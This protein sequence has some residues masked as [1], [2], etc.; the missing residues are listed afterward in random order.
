MRSS[1]DICYYDTHKAGEMGSKLSTNIDKIHDGIGFKLY[2]L[3]ALFFSCINTTI[4]AF[5]IN[6]KLTLI[7]LVLLPSFILT[8]LMTMK[9]LQP[10]S[11]SAAIAQEIFSSIRTI[12]AYNSSEYEQLRKKGIVFGC[13]MA[14]IMNFLLIGSLSQNIHSL[15]EACGAATEIWQTLDE[16]ELLNNNLSQTNNAIEENIDIVGDIEFNNVQFSYPTRKD[17]K[18]LDNLNLVVSHGDKVALVGS[19]GAGKSS[20]FHLLLRFYEPTSGTIRID[21]RS[22]QEYNLTWLRQQIGLVS[23]EPILFGTT[24]YENILYGNNRKNKVSMSEIEEA[25]KQANAD[26]FIMRLP[27]K[28][29]TMVGERGIHLSGGQKQRIAIARALIGN[30]KILLFDEATSALDNLNE[31]IVQEAID[32]ACKG[33]TTI[34]IAHRLSTIRNVDCINVISKGQIIERANHNQL[35]LNKQGQYYQTVHKQNLPD[36][37]NEDDFLI[38]KEPSEQESHSTKIHRHFSQESIDGDKNESGE[39]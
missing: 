36:E 27:N 32:S 29:Y 35:I 30:P 13:Y 2:S 6:W 19:S 14:I 1:K 17:I 10:N 31:K 5:I 16:E 33:R 15:S 23:Q 18:V 3:M 21:G 8:A 22:I 25:S 39:N 12:F 20:C 24:I 7:M 28:Y 37:D 11:K 4:L 9:E 34:F 38:V 26:E